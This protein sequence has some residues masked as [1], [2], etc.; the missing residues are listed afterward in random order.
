MH[1]EIV[2]VSRQKIVKVIEDL[3]TKSNTRTNPHFLRNVPG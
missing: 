3:I 2:Q 1:Y